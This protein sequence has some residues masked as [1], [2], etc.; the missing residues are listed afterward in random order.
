MAVCTQFVEGFLKQSAESVANCSNY[1]LVTSDEYN[2]FTEVFTL[3]ATMIG[4]CIG[5]GFG[6]VVSIYF[7]GY[8]IMVAQKSIK[9]I[10]K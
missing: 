7:A 2:V 6:V 10:G 1:V 4:T 8:P 3:D 5:F 9:L